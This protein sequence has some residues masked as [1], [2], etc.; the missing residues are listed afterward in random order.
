MTYLLRL[1]ATSFLQES[2]KEGIIRS[3]S[4]TYQNLSLLLAL[5][6]LSQPVF[7]EHKIK[8]LIG[9]ILIPSKHITVQAVIS[10]VLDVATVTTDTDENG[11]ETDN[12]AGKSTFAGS[13]SNKYDKT[14]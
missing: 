4:D 13:K 8:D 12:N 7:N 5:G 10:G 2:F 3:F 11:N 14:Q 6:P 1:R 9:T